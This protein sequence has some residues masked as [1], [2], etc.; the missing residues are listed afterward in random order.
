MPLIMAGV[1][2]AAI[3]GGTSVGVLFAT[4]KP[5]K[6]PQVNIDQTVLNE[7]IF[8]FMKKNTVSASQNVVVSQD[9]NISG[10]QFI[11]C[12]PNI[13]QTADVEVKLLQSITSE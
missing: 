11:G 9:I 10:V 4:K 1:A 7:K 2:T 13:S 8:N 6:P 12:K 5:A 3:V